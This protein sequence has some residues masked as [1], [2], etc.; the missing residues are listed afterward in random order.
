MGC[1]G[2]NSGQ[3][4]SQ[5]SSKVDSSQVH[6]DGDHDFTCP[7]HPNQHSK[8]PGKCPECGMDMVHTDGAS[9]ETFTL[10]FA[11][12]PANAEAGKTTTISLRPTIDGKP[13]VDVPLELLHEKKVHLI[14]VSDDLQWF[15]HGHPEYQN[16][17]SYTLAQAFPFGGNFHLFADYKPSGATQQLQKI[18]LAV[19]G[20]PVAAK[21]YDKA[22]LSS[23]VGGYEVKL[24]TTNGELESGAMQHIAASILKGGKT[25]DPNTLDDY[26]GAKAHVVVIGMEDKDYLHVHP[27][28]EGNQLDLHATFAKP[29]IYRCWVQ[30]QSNGTVI[31]AD[32]VLDVK[33]GDAGENNEAHE[34]EHGEEGHSHSH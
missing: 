26:L 33:L 19:T 12:T 15:A 27:D 32:F 34:H 9:S 14:M 6:A 28:V 23:K 7:M 17:G 20:K 16:D 30:F 31:V 5:D 22:Q 2:G 24:S 13:G 29:G 4:G 11:T 1:N 8:G 25:V 10:E 3:S 21:V 18:T